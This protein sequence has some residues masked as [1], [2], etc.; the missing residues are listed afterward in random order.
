MNIFKNSLNICRG[1][2]ERG[3]IGEIGGIGVMGII[4]IIGIIGVIGIFSKFSNLPKRKR[5]LKRKGDSKEP[6]QKNLTKNRL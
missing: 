3:L 5:Q 1:Y 2:A 6:P 4:G